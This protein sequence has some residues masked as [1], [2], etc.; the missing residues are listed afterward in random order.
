MRV[1]FLQD[2]PDVARAGEIKEVANGYGRNY[3]IPQKLAL[4]AKPGATSMIET[5]PRIKAQA[6]S[7]AKLVELAHHLEGKEV[8]LK[9]RAGAKERLYGSITPADIATELQ[10][11]AGLVVDK[12]KIELA[13]PI[14]QLGSY[15]VAI[16]LAGDIVPKIKVTVTEEETD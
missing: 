14:R 2:V 6:E 11:S 16:R 5:Q 1:I 12:K 9:A 7:Q 13:E 8:T 4:P 10:N 3:L 15:E